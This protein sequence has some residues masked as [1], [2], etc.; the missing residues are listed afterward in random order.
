MHVCTG[1][2]RQKLLRPIDIYRTKVKTKGK[3]ENHRFLCPPPP[4]I[5]KR[6]L[7]THHHHHPTHTLSSVVAAVSSFLDFLSLPSGSVADVFRFFLFADFGARGVGHLCA[8]RCAL[9]PLALPFLLAVAL[10]TALHIHQR[11][12]LR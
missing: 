2:D 4:Y 11:N 6:L 8:R 5:L 1:I 10:P 9:V 7:S 3:N 12:S